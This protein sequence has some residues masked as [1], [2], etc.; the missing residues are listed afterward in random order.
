M[1]IGGIKKKMSS[2][3]LQKS[4]SNI[5]SSA[6]C[7]R[8]C[9]SD[10]ESPIGFPPTATWG[11]TTSAACAFLKQ[12][13]PPRRPHSRL[14]SVA[15]RLRSWPQPLFLFRQCGQCASRPPLNVGYKFVADIYNRCDY[16]FTWKWH[17]E[18]VVPSHAGHLMVWYDVILQKRLPQKRKVN[19]CTFCAIYKTYIPKGY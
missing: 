11:T 16:V 7:A 3:L 17:M 2:V 15:W 9:R 5:K 10:A 12:A 6:S 13:S 4:F 14:Q 1:I 8:P 18:M 19:K